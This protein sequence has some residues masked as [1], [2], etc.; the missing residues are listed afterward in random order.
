MSTP[1]DTATLIATSDDLLDDEQMRAKYAPVCIGP[2]WLRDG[3][4]AWLLP[5][6]TLGWEIAGWLAKWLR[7][8]DGSDHFKLT[9]EQL[10]FVLWWYAVDESG[11]FTYRAG[12]LQ[13]LKGWGKDPLA[14]ALCLVEL[15]GPSR[16]GGWAKDGSPIGVPCPTAL[17]QIA[18]V[19]Q[20]QTQNTTTMFAILMTDA[21]RAHYGVSDGAEVIH[22]L[23]GR[24]HLQAV[25][26]SPRALEGG[27]ATFVIANEPHQWIAGNRGHAMWDVIERNLTKMQGRVLAITN[28]YEP[29][30]DSVG[31]HL[32][33]SWEKVNEGR[34]EDT[35][36]LYDSLEAPPHAGLSRRV[37]EIVLSLVRGDSVWLDIPTIVQ[38]ILDVN[39]A[40]SRS[41][42]FWY[43]QVVA[44]EDALYGPAQWDVM[45][46]EGAELE[47]GDE[48]VLGFDGGKTDDATALIAVR[49]RDMCVFVVNVWEKPDGPAADGW[50]VP[51]ELVD[52]TVREQFRLYDVKGFYADVALW[53]SFIY[54][55]E[56]DLGDQLSVKASDRSPI[57]YDMR[58]SVKAV[59]RAHERLMRTIFD[60]K[61]LHDGNRTLRR[62]VLNARRASNDYG[63][64]FRKESR[65]SPRKV[66]AY[67]AMLL[68]FQCL[69]DLN[70][71]GKSERKRT[72]RGWFM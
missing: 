70:S 47:A 72:G 30:E 32:R 50:Q 43:N 57:G 22:A 1:S 16:F 46:S 37:A 69:Y 18:A 42:R 4:G 24:V 21:F 20:F 64:S 44:E 13:R 52:E 9:L 31:Q 6:R 58:Q 49:L 40:P 66:D 2:T 10:R 7:G 26:S 54:E 34:A 62:H 63:V 3:D 68:A 61:L 28:A 55:W 8:P 51:R 17:V 53:E 15:V 19:N 60:R 14:A 27:R 33:E 41:R 65:E 48:I 71:R 23:N 39:N 67:A 56:R 5:E 36:W 12:V 38:S 59:T 25:T 35:G 29:G 11:R 45:L